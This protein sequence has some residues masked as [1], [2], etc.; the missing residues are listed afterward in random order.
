[1]HTC[2]LALCLSLSHAPAP[3]AADR[4][5]GEDKFK[6]YVM[7]F[8]VTSLAASGAR[9]AGAGGRAGL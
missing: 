4:W 5:L 1:M 9:A 7:S 2:L 6:H 3:R 8:F